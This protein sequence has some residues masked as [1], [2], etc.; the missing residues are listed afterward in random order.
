MTRFD[1]HPEDLLER[2]QRGSAS[3]AEL[4]RLEQHLA[5]CAVCRV[6]R[7]LSQQA[8]LDVAPLRDEKLMVA[9]LKRDVGERL[10]SS[11]QRRAR[12]KGAVIAVTL[13]AASLASVAAAATMV[14]VQRAPDLAGVPQT[15]PA[16][17]P[18]PHKAARPAAAP[19][20]VLEEPNVLEPEAALP[21]TPAQ[22][23]PVE[24]GSASELFSR[25][26]QARREGKVK[27]AVRL[28]RALQDRYSGS[29]EE[30]VSRVALG[31]LLLDRLGDSRG[32]LVQ[33]NSYL[34]SPGRGALREEA[35]VGRALA[36]GRG[37][38]SAEE[39][40]AWKALLDSWPKSTHAKRA[41]ARLAELDRQ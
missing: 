32:A 15:A 34:A 37:G 35:M 10:R 28:Y 20:S 26:N 40:A 9:R 5:E 22:P 36:L 24:T 11:P 38:R 31:R 29:S 8:A 6:E 27:D 19:P 30:L 21:E 18:K 12:G 39:R 13:I 3:D 23:T 33:F 14:L 7:A 17:A 16:A 1:L 4:A 2:A 41:Q 25:A